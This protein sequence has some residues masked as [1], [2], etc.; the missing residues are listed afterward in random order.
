MNEHYS[1]KQIIARTD[2]MI[3]KNQNDLIKTQD[4]MM[5]QIKS[6]KSQLKEQAKEEENLDKTVTEP[7]DLSYL[8]QKSLEILFALNRQLND[9]ETL[10]FS[11]EGIYDL[12][13]DWVSLV[14]KNNQGGINLTEFYRSF[15]SI[16][17]FVISDKDIVNIFKLFDMNGDGDISVQELAK[18]IQKTIDVCM[19]EGGQELFDKLMKEGNNEDALAVGDREKIREKAGINNQKIK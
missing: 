3:Q 19:K 8:H 17:D 4:W 15:G 5:R 6:V 18:A 10:D 7:V 16:D 11:P 2:D 1:L 14:D 9:T 13:F 12:A